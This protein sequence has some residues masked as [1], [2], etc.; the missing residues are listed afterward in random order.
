M[1]V[2][3]DPTVLQWLIKSGP[4][5]FPSLRCVCVYL[6]RHRLLQLIAAAFL[7]VMIAET[8]VRFSASALFFLF[9]FT[10]VFSFLKL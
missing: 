10:S 2:A 5:P 4:V 7:S 8:V 6:I 1:A 9:Y 3:I